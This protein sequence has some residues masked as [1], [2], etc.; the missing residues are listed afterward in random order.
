MIVLV[1]CHGMKLEIWT[2]ELDWVVKLPWSHTPI[3]PASSEVI[4]MS[5]SDLQ[6]PLAASGRAC[7]SKAVPDEA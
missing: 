6:C 2:N 7:C 5:D 1:S 3:A 4:R